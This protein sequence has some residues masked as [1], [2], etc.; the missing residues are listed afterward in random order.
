MNPHKVCKLAQLVMD[1]H[2]SDM[3]HIEGFQLHTELHHLSCLTAPEQ[4]DR[5]MREILN[6]RYTPPQFEAPFPMSHPSLDHKLIPHTQ[7]TWESHGPGLTTPG[8]D[9]AFDIEHWA[10]Y[11]FYHGRPGCP[12]PFISVAFNYA[13]HIHYRSI[14]RHLLCRALAPASS[15]A[16]AIFTHHFV[17]LTA[18]PRRY[19]DFIQE[20]P[21]VEPPQWTAWRLP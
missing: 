13:F 12:N 16:W 2:H 19:R 8:P 1:R 21:E 6:K 5:S 14:F 17:C 10:R 18:V 11:I 9:S 3:D 20:C 4:C 7:L 15:V